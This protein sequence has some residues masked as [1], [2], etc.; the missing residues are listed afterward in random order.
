MVTDWNF[1]WWRK[2]SPAYR[3]KLEDGRIFLERWW[4]GIG[5]L[6]NSRGYLVAYRRILDGKEVLTERSITSEQI[7]LPFIARILAPAIA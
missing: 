2:T 4:E 1:W 6:Y 3:V 5:D 7:R